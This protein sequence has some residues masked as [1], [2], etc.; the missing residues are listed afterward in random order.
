MYSELIFK[1]SLWYIIQDIVV[2]TLLLSGICFVLDQL[3]G[4]FFKKGR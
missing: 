1:D 3:I 2:V 4:K